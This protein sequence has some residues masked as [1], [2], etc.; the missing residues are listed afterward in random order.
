M[1]SWLRLVEAVRTRHAGI[2]SATGVPPSVVARLLLTASRMEGGKGDEP[3]VGDEQFAPHAGPAYGWYQM[4]VGYEAGRGWQP[5]GRHLMDD[6]GW[7]LAD[8]LD[9]EKVVEYI[10]PLF[11]LAWSKLPEGPSRERDAIFNVERP[12]KPYPVAVFAAASAAADR[13]I[14]GWRGGVQ[15]HPVP[16]RRSTH[17]D[18]PGLVVPNGRAFRVLY[19]DRTNYYSPAKAKRAY[20][21]ADGHPRHAGL[22]MH[23]AEEKADNREVTP[24]WCANPASNVSVQWYLDNDGDLYLLLPYDDA[25]PWA[26]GVYPTGPK[27]NVNA[28]FALTFDW[29]TYGSPNVAF[30]A[31]EWEGEAATIGKTITPEQFATGATLTAWLATTHGW[32]IGR[33]SRGRGDI[34]GHQEISTSKSDPGPHFPWE[35]VLTRAREIQRTMTTVTA[36]GQ[37]GGIRIQ[38][39][40]VSAELRRLESLIAAQRGEISALREHFKA[41]P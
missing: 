21:I 31:V 10:G 27:R 8:L 2:A 22:V 40:A 28:T 7:S 24:E 23:T 30:D 38:D 4:N 25:V 20:S 5:M 26:Q 16:K 29:D 18:F 32:T 12:A 14:R 33:G 1:T 37:R 3:G 6:L 15:S 34:W 13:I 9:E 11:A 17:E 41:T 39:Q 36:V 19:A 35:D